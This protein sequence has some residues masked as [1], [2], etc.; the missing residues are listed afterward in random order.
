ME[1]RSALPAYLK[2]WWLCFSPIALPFAVRVAWEKTVWTWTRGP[3][4]VG[5]SLMHIHPMF[6]IVG[7]FCSVAVM[8][9]LVVAIPYSIVR[10]RMVTF[11]DLAMIAFAML[12]TAAVIIPDNFFA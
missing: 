7:I 3:Q 6:A 5:F 1:M 9:W 10:R 11:I 12:V 4:L 2:V 8:L